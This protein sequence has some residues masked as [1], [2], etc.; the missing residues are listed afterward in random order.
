[1]RSWL[2]AIVISVACHSILLWLLAQHSV[3]APVRAPQSSIKTY[4]VVAP[5]ER[6]PDPAATE[7]PSQPPTEPILSPEQQ[8][9]PV[10]PI[11]E[12]KQAVSNVV[13]AKTDPMTHTVPQPQAQQTKAHT[14][15]PYK[16]I[17]PALGLSRLRQ[18]ML[19]QPVTRHKPNNSQPKRLGVP[20]SHQTLNQPMRQIESKNHIFTEY[21][22]G[23]RCYKEVQGDP[24]NPPP[25]GFAK[26]WLTAS[27]TCDKTAITDAY[28]AAMDKWLKKKR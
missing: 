18:Q 3:V 8:V 17:D 20:E 9:T 23:D 16:R 4:L 26:N 21:R 14:S 1:M 2:S 12:K 6:T 27:S 15:K 7:Q 28:D 24:N 5:P 10:Q 22:E 19:N 11:P 13:S 25:E